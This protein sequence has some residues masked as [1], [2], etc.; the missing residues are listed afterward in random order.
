MLTGDQKELYLKRLGINETLYPPSKLLAQLHIAHLRHVPF[1]NLDIVY[2]RDITLSDEAIFRKLIEEKR[3]G[4]CYE[5]NYGFYLLLSSLGFSVQLLSAR[6]YGKEGYG[7]E[8]DHLMLRVDLEGK[9]V[10]AD[11]G[12]GDG[13]LHPIP[14]NGSVQEEG[15][16]RFQVTK[17]QDDLYLMSSQDSATWQPQYRFT[18]TARKLNHFSAMARYHQTSSQSSFTQKSI[19]TI[20]TQNGRVTLGDRKLKITELGEKCERNI[21]SAAEYVMLLQTHFGVVLP[22]RFSI[23]D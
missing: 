18:L 11:V 12:F 14:L 22:E 10:I 4:F 23:E 19:C 5:L 8:F 6:V 1:E 20:A 17:E 7:Q 21:L 15:N 2:G 3:G 13:F 16:S 9:S